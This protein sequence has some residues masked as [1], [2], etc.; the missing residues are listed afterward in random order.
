VIDL[1]SPHEQQ[2]LAIARV[3]LHGPDWL[4]LDKSTSA[5]DEER[6]E[7]IYALL[8]EHLPGSTLVSIAH[9]PGVERHHTRHW[10]LSPRKGRVAL[11]V[12]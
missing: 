2:R 4:F 11:E 9:R 3:L 6:E 5:L 12:A 7:Q 1:L 10:T 8:A